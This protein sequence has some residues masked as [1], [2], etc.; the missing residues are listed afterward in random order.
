LTA[1][2]SDGQL[3]RAAYDVRTLNIRGGAASE[4]ETKLTFERYAVQ[5]MD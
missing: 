4:H 3:A 2:A 5:Y 1:R